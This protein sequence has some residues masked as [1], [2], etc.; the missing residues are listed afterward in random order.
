MAY[1]N[2]IMFALVSF[3]V[4]RITIVF[5]FLF[6]IVNCIINKMTKKDFII[7]GY[8]I[9]TLTPDLV[10]KY[11]N[12]ICKSLDQIP[13]VDPHT[14]EQ[15]LQAKSG[16]R[17]L[18]KKW[19]HSFLLLDEENFVGV[20][21]G[22][23]RKSENNDQYPYNSIYLSDFAVAKE[24]QRK[25]IGKFLV[26]IWLDKNR[27]I[28]FLKLD[29]HLRF[30]VQTNLADWNEHVKKL[31]ESFGFKKTSEKKY[32]NRTDNIYFL[33]VFKDH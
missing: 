18:Y 16:D 22:Y 27:I 2:H 31:Y 1:E 9:F 28:G 10:E 13:R 19:D 8:E 23:E 30:S 12:D 3:L 11:G 20:I 21:M 6:V 17:V 14:K 33:E 15:L 29:G 26:K 32:D 5:M 25:G 24:Y 7:R 4:A